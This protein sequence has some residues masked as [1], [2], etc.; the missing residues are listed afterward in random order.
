MYLS[1]IHLRTARHLLNIG[2]RE[3]GIL[4]SAS[5]TTVS[6]LENNIISLSDMKLGTR[7]NIILHEF[8]KKHGICFPNLYTLKL[9]PKK[10][11]YLNNTSLTCYQIKS[12]RIILN[13]T[14]N[15]LASEA[16]IGISIL[17]RLENKQSFNNIAINNLKNIFEE[18]GIL[19]P[20]KF[21]IV[22]KTLVDIQTL[23]C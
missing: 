2:V 11:A 19:F 12:A 1:N 9:H 8:F 17:R 3:I 4:I 5:R 10:F 14:Q 22:F 16:E 21:S 7:R 15:E 23:K 18:Y 20:D 13:K 6:K